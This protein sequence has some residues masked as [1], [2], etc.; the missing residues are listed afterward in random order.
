M[1]SPTSDIDLSPSS[2]AKVGLTP[3]T[4]GSL[5]GWG[6]RQGGA[7]GWYIDGRSDDALVM[8]VMSPS[9]PARV[10]MA[11]GGTGSLVPTL[12]YR[13]GHDGQPHHSWLDPTGI[14]ELVAIPDADARFLVRMLHADPDLAAL[15]DP[16]DGEGWSASDPI[17]LVGAIVCGSAIET[18]PAPVHEGRLSPSRVAALRSAQRAYDLVLEVAGRLIG[19]SGPWGQGVVPVARRVADVMVARYPDLIP[20][21]AT[22]ALT[23]TI[24]RGDLPMMPALESGAAWAD[25]LLTTIW[26]AWAFGPRATV[27]AGRELVRRSQP[28]LGTEATDRLLVGIVVALQLASRGASHG[29]TSGSTG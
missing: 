16:D 11:R 3:G 5:V 26:A 24:D 2:R 12:S 7:Q 10:A 23:R 27:G 19:S 20:R 9:T 25:D 8:Y 28:D 13:R 14:A 1:V 4:V 17:F 22:D 21:V 29:A 18:W 15:G 6:L